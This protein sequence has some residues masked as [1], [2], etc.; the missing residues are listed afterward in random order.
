MAGNV[1]AIPDGY[2]SAIPYL[3]IK[4]ATKAIEFYRKAFGATEVMRYPAPDGKI[5]HAELKIGN[6]LFMLADEYP[7]MGHREPNSIGGT[8]VSVMVY[9][10]D[11]DAL[12]RNAQLSGAKVRRPLSDQFYGDRSCTLE[13]PFG[14]VWHFATHKEDVSAEEMHRRMKQTESAI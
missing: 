4:G 6:A 3:I 8:P 12:A 1:K 14:H 7:E 5:G 9:V 2:G 10:Q 13:D 11:V